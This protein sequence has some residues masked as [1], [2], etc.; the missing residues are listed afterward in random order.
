MSTNVLAYTSCVIPSA[1]E[2]SERD[3]VEMTAEV[4]ML[5]PTRDNSVIVTL[6]LKDNK[7]GAPIV[8]RRVSVHTVPESL[9]GADWRTVDGLAVRWPEKSAA[10]LRQRVSQGLVRLKSAL[11]KESGVTDSTGTFAVRVYAWHVCGPEAVP[12]T[13]KVI[14]EYGN[15]S[16]AHLVRCGMNLVEMTREVAWKVQLSPRATGRFVQPGVIDRLKKIGPQWDDVED[17]PPST[18]F[19]IVISEASIR[20][21]GLTPPHLT[22]RFGG[23]LDFRV[24]SGDGGPSSPSSANYDRRGVEWLCW[25]CK[26]Q[27]ATEIRFADAVPGVTTIDP[28]H[29]D[30]LH[31]SFLKD[32][33]E[34]WLVS[35]GREPFRSAVE[36]V[37]A[38]ASDSSK[39][40]QRPFGR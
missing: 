34:H 30:H 18:D 36:R 23:T 25:L 12:A 4:P 7:S 33:V 27:G 16:V 2:V 13:D 1:D 3:H 39:S 40:L 28:T 32:P 35:A 5:A 17:G 14:F 8:G 37:R 29:A 21:G 6:T 10:I 11:D 26:S 9:S 20:W 31:V 15:G 19:P 38:A 22:H 24:P